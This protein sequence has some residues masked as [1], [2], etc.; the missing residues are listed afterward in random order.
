MLVFG[1]NKLSTAARSRPTA[2]YSLQ[3]RCLA[4]L[5]SPQPHTPDS[6]GEDNALIALS[7]AGTSKTRICTICDVTLVSSTKP[8]LADRA[9]RHH[10]IPK[11]IVKAAERV[12]SQA[13]LLAR[14]S[15]L[16]GATVDVC[17]GCH[18]YLHSLCTHEELLKYGMTGE[19]L[20]A[21][22]L[23]SGW[24]EYV[25]NMLRPVSRI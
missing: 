2:L 23:A 19:K 6:T 18:A 22:V 12:P 11:S 5:P 21:L 7:R 13:L 9:T 1:S 8:R 25:H 17:A 4:T 15:T 14:L 20:R 3:R 16:E 10:L 24:L